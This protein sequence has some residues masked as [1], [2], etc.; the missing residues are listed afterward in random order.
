MECAVVVGRCGFRRV[1]LVDA[2]PEVGGYAA[3]AARLPS[4]GEWARVVNW[5][6]TQLAKLPNVEVITGLEIDAPATREYGAE[7]VVIA[8]GA[9]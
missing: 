8:T 3:L 1:H 9:R 6:R 2:A 5:R 7:I 4:L